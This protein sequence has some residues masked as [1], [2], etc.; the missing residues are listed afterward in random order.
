VEAAWR[1]ISQTRC[2]H[3]P[4]G[5]IGFAHDLLIKPLL[6]TAEGM[7]ARPQPLR[8][9]VPR[10]NGGAGCVFPGS[11]V[12]DDLTLILP[13]YVPDALERLGAGSAKEALP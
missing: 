9:S 8:A 10:K 1:R 11:D 3:P 4:F 5:A 7:Q 13:A 12:G 2:C 6:F